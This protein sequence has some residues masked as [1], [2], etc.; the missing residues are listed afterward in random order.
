MRVGQMFKTVAL[1]RSC[2]G[3]VREY[4][5]VQA[6][7]DGTKPMP[8]ST[9]QAHDVRPYTKTRGKYVMVLQQ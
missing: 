6:F 4:P 9:Q 3:I 8:A 1:C 5:P 7:L 2:M